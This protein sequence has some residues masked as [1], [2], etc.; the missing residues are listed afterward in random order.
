[1]CL[2]GCT[3]RKKPKGKSK[4]IKKTKVSCPKGV[5]TEKEAEDIFK[6]LAKNPDIP[7]D[8]PVDC[9]YSRAHEMC[10]IMESKGIQCNKYW[11][12]DKDWGTMAM[13]PSLEP[14]D[15]AGNPITFPDS[16]GNK[17]QVRWVYHVAP[18]VRVMKSD[19]TVEERVID[20]S[21]ANQPVTKDEWKKIMGNPSGS[22]AEE[23]KSQAYFQNKKHG[24]T[25]SGSNS[26]AYKEDPTG[27][28]AKKQMKKHKKQR[29]INNKKAA[30]KIGSKTP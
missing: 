2:S 13:K 12:F 21:I 16:S 26:H 15:K 20:P 22:Y 29:D 7:F 1:M 18:I 30:K 8:Y 6:E 11:L 5:M 24:V 19:G 3:P 23:S 17:Q 10:R 9:C 28:E 4:T 25:P 27:Q 14:K